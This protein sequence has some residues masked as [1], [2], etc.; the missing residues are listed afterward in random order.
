[1]REEWSRSENFV[2]RNEFTARALYQI[3]DF[4]TL[5]PA[6]N[7][8][9]PCVAPLICNGSNVTTLFQQCV[10]LDQL[11]GRVESA[12]SQA[13]NYYTN[14][15]FKEALNLSYNFL[16]YS[17]DPN[18]RVIVGSSPDLLVNGFPRGGGTWEN[19]V[20]MDDNTPKIYFNDIVNATNA[21]I[22][23]S[24]ASFYNSSL[25]QNI[26][27]GTINGQLLGLFINTPFVYPLEWS[28]QVYLYF[29]QA[30]RTSAEG[31]AGTTYLAGRLTCDWLVGDDYSGA[32]KRFSI[33]QMFVMA[34]GG[35][36][37]VAIFFLYVYQV[38]FFSI[39]F[40]TSLSTGIWLVSFLI[41]YE[42]YALTCFPG[43]PV[44]FFN[45]I[46][47]FFAY[48]AFPKCSWFWGFL[49]QS[50]YTNDNC[51]SCINAQSFQM[52]Q[53]QD[54]GFTDFT[55][56]AIF[57][58]QFYYPQV[59]EWIRTTRS[60]IYIL[61]QIPYFNQRINAYVNVNMND[62]VIYAKYM[63]CNYIVTFF[64]NLNL[65]TL[66][67][68]LALFAVPYIS[69]AVLVGW[70]VAQ[71][72]WQLFLILYLIYIDVVILL[73]TLPAFY[74]AGTGRRANGGSGTYS[75]RYGAHYDGSD[76][77]EEDDSQQEEERRRRRVRQ[78]REQRKIMSQ[79]ELFVASEQKRS[80]LASLGMMFS[81]WRD[82]YFGDRKNR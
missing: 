42:N 18:A 32:V 81:R 35:Y 64:P 63:G 2:L 29:S 34:G 76:D 54:L 25:V 75:S 44:I 69:A 26:D 50:E 74:Y 20:Y 6:T 57:I 52:L 65:L 72:L 11:V 40:A 58:I 66:Y 67:G 45:D 14:G 1:M 27:Y 82:R 23:D 39:V 60:P 55:S 5:T 48:N 61:Y 17:F 22:A 3:A 51:Y 43:L 79:E 9:F 62:P 8:T 30:N 46:F 49:V 73:T 10:Y 13:I 36:F 37:P 15:P 71:I 41:I 77:D 70:L 59:L 78:P 56:N 24:N 12:L 31:A 80:L 7:I 38:N 33:G 19:L 28:Y 53:C 47:Y 4:L 68:T 21:F 16:F